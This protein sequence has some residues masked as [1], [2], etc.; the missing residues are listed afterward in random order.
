MIRGPL[1]LHVSRLLS[2][3]DAF[4]LVSDGRLLASSAAD[5]A[6]SGLLPQAIHTASSYFPMGEGDLILIKD[7]F[8]GG[9]GRDGF[10][11]V[12]R[13][14]EGDDS[15]PSLWLATRLNDPSFR[16]LRLPPAPL[17]LGGEI[18]PGV[19][20]ALGAP[21]EKAAALEEDL[22]R[23][24]QTFQLEALT[25]LL[26]KR[27][28]QETFSREKEKMRLLLSELPE[29]DAVADLTLPTGEV[30]KARLHCD[31][32]H[33]EF[34][35][36][37]TSPGKSMFLPLSATSGVVW[38]AMLEH[39]GLPT[40]VNEACVNAMPLTVPNGCCLNAKGGT[41]CDRGLE[42]GRAWLQLLME[43]LLHKWDR[44]KPR[45]LMNPFDLH[46]RLK[47]DDGRELHLRLPA[48][49]PGQ[50]E[51]EGCSFWLQRPGADEFSVEKIEKHWPIKVRRLDERVSPAG[52]GRFN[53]GRGLHLHLELQA[54]ADLI[55]FSPGPE[56][57]LKTE[58]HQSPFDGN[59]LRLSK[60]GG[61][62]IA[63]CEKRRLEAGTT[64]IL[65]SGSGGG[66]V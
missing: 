3:F 62:K 43:Q 42:E 66:L 48:G 51:L 47:F 15:N 45:G 19:M 29:G 44:R 27:A 46:A 22:G 37:G 59:D 50:D 54:G 25:S 57:R 31:G 10:A 11:V 14:R 55:W 24:R 49:T 23:C 26:T 60:E 35:F 9:P 65:L 32:Q 64:M 34:D 12:Y 18:N 6:D 30:L 41:D 7:P 38:T 56:A 33:V 52:K 13:L 58:K 53:G 2:R 36:S 39:L 28:L 16:A 20:E 1:S 40:I 5:P 17:R 4:A 61:D 63:P 8:A 21:R